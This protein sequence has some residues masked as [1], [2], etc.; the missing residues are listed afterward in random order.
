L[1]LPE[2]QDK[3]DFLASHVCFFYGRRWHLQRDVDRGVQ[4]LYSFVSFAGL[5]DRSADK[6]AVKQ[7][8]FML[9]G[10]ADER[11]SSSLEEYQRR[12]RNIEGKNL[13]IQ[14]GFLSRLLATCKERQ[15]KLIVMNMPLSADN[16]KLL[17]EG[18]YLRFSDRVREMTVAS[19][20]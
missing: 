13:E 14:M 10:N 11:W 17:P 19:G 18:F 5:Q 12:Y 8:G 9:S 2:W 4:K 6:P 20:A 7:A 15:I 3:A 16:R 1:Y